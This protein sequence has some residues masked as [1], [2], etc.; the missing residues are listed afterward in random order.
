MFAY[1][2]WNK[3]YFL[4]VGNNHLID[5][6]APINLTYAWS[7]GS[8]AGICL[9]VQIITGIFL[10][11][12]YS[13]NIELAF[14]SV[15]HI[16][17]N[18]QGG[19]LMRYIHANGASMFFAVV[20][21]HI[22]RGI[23][24]CSFMKPRHFL[25]CTGVAIF[26]LMMATAFIGY[27]LPWG[28]MSYWGATVITNLVTALPVVGQGIVNWLWGGFSISNAT[29][30]RFF[31]FHFILP[32]IVAIVVASHLAVLHKDGSNNPLG[33]DSSMDKV[34]FYPYFYVKDMLA[35]VFFLSIYATFL[36]MS[37]NYLGHP[38]NYIP[39]DSMA[40]PPHIVPEWYFLPF[41]AILRS[42]PTKFSGVLAMV[43][44]ILVLF[45]LPYIHSS[46]VRTPAFQPFYSSFFW[47]VFLDFLLLGYIGQAPIE[48]HFV[49]LGRIATFFYFFLFLF[50][51][52]YLGDLERKFIANDLK[53]K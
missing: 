4:S 18:V 39:A 31:C 33:I 41:Y 47:C 22:F 49:L 15:E 23:Y 48:D 13:P 53:F 2:R 14:D 11:M 10:T 37:P 34:Y 27:V 32:F 30:N 36:F 9:V 40:T 52:P 20:Y 25:W 5:Y 24:F 45:L 46:D 26:F 50:V 51:Y 12:H 44:A 29:L 19:W 3:D 16:M 8:L 42:L 7:F 1:Q 17:R 6:P 28:Q 21:C 38:D 35:L 43:G